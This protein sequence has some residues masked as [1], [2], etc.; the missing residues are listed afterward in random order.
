MKE[1]YNFRINR[2]KGYWPSGE[3][4]ANIKIIFT[5]QNLEVRCEEYK[6]KVI[7]PMKNPTGTYKISDILKAKYGNIFLIFVP[8]VILLAIIILL[9]MSTLFDMKYKF[10]YE[11]IAIS[12]ILIAVYI[13]C[14][15]LKAIKINLKNGEKI[16]IPIKS[17][18]F[19]SIEQKEN[20]Q[21]IIDEI[22]DLIKGK[23]VF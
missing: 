13:I 22:N 1:E 14:T 10:M 9:A 7:N 2:L 11:P 16:Y 20:T 18:R 21:R 12:I 5:E 15:R 3:Y 8:Q 17:L 23:K 6:E 4:S 19:E